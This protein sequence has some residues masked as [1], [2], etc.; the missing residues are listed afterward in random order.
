MGK[1]FCAQEFS[2][3]SASLSGLSV[4]YLDDGF[5][6]LMF[7]GII[8]SFMGATSRERGVWAVCEAATTS[9]PRVHGI[10]EGA[11]TASELPKDTDGGDGTWSTSPVP[12][13]NTCATAWVTGSKGFRA[14]DSAARTP[15]SMEP[16]SRWTT[17]WG[18]QDRAKSNQSRPSNRSEEGESATGTSFK[19]IEMT[20][21]SEGSVRGPEICES[22]TRSPDLM[23]QSRETEEVAA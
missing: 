23:T 4:R 22:S 14:V 1:K 13:R 6:D 3:L 11:D 8:S 5:K 19:R 17:R 7:M 12:P 15:K 21:T 10:E 20:P 2:I 16:E 18:A 9:I